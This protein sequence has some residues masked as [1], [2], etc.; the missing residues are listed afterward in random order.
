MINNLR[1]A[2]D[3]MVHVEM[4]EREVTQV[5]VALSAAQE[6]IRNLKAHMVSDGDTVRAETERAIKMLCKFRETWLENA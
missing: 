4:V 1:E 3:I 5:H 6:E 2:F